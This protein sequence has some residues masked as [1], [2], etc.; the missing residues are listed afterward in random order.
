[1]AGLGR[2]ACVDPGSRWVVTLVGS[3]VPVALDSILC[4]G[5]WRLHS[6]NTGN[7]QQRQANAEALVHVL[8]LYIERCIYY[9]LTC[10]RVYELVMVDRGL[11][12]EERTMSVKTYNRFMAIASVVV[13]GGGSIIVVAGL[14]ELLLGG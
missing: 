8:Y 4:P 12:E 3:E 5:R 13:F 2:V 7:R 1:M 6:C 11:I 10:T 9:I 14:L